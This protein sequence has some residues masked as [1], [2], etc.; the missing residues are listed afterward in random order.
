[1]SRSGLNELLRIACTVVI[2]IIV[3]S[4]GYIFMHGW[5]I[6]NGLQN[7]SDIVSVDITQNGETVTVTDE[8]DILLACRTVNI[9]KVKPT[10]VEGRTPDTIYVFKFQDGSEETVGASY[11]AVFKNGKAYSGTEDSCGLFDKVTEG[12]FFFESAVL[13]DSMGKD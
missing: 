10:K 1:M 6:F 4:A 5:P 3:V 12:I 2:T 13:R 11:D 8:Q 9:L 7:R